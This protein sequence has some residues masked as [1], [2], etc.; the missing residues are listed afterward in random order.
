MTSGN[1]QSKRERLH[2]ALNPQTVVVVGAKKADEYQWLKNMSTFTGKV[3]SVQVDPNEI[4]GIEEMGIKNYTSLKDIP[5]PVDFVLCAVPR[6]VAPRIVKDCIDV[7]VG[8][9][10]LYTSGF[11]ETGSEEGVRLQ[12]VITD[13]AKEA[14]LVLVGPNCMGIYNPRLGVRFTQEQATG[15]SG[16]VTFLSQSGSQGSGFGAECRS[17]GIDVCKVVSYGNGVVLDSPDYLEYFVEDPETQVIGMYVEGARDGRRLFKTLREVARRKPVVIW[18]GGQTPDSARATRSHTASL[19]VSSVMWETLVKQTGVLPVHGMEDLVDM[20]KALLFTKPF[21]GTRLGLIAVSG[22]H[23]VEIADAFSMQGLNVPPLSD[24]SY[25]RLAGFFSVIGGS[26]RN[27][28]E[29]GGNLASEEK[30]ADILDILEDDPNVDAV[31]VEMGSFARRN[32]SIL[33]RRVQT[34][35]DFKQKTKK[36]LWACWGAGMMRVDPEVQGDATLKLQ[37]GG[38]PCFASFYRAARAM[39]RFVRHSRWLQEQ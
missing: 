26:Y 36:T 20:C 8:G 7:G 22:G 21:T 38:I 32:P 29:G 5:D 12:Q 34:L 6:P 25:E 2:R 10:V 23:S 18:K 4:P 1:V 28:L 37:Q 17:Q 33:E 39:G 30:V 24:A 15:V 11:A 14:D 3:Y 16:H 31:V 13:M 27:P 19:A 9:V 35:I